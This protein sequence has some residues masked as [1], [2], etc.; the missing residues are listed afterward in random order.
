ML[1]LDLGPTLQTLNVYVQIFQ[2]SETEIKQ[3]L[4]QAFWARDLQPVL[5]TE[6]TG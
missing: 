5:G 1:C 4:F 2:I 6:I 3:F